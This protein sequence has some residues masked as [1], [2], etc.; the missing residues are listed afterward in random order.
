MF[1]EEFGRDYLDIYRSNDVPI[2]PSDVLSP[3]IINL[4]ITEGKGGRFEALVMHSKAMFL[5]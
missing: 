2:F 4:K 1:E 3:K 5:T